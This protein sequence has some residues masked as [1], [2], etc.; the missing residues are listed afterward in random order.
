MHQKDYNL[1]LF[2][3]ILASVAISANAFVISYM[4]YYRYLRNIESNAERSL[5]QRV[6]DVL[7]GGLRPDSST[8]SACRRSFIRNPF[9]FAILMLHVSNIGEEITLIPWIYKGNTGL[10]VF[11]EAVKYYFSL[12]NCFSWF[13][14]IQVYRLL[15]FSDFAKGNVEKVTIGDTFRYF[16]YHPDFRFFIYFMFF[17]FPLV[18]FIPFITGSYR[19]SSIPWCTTSINSDFYVGFFLE[20]FWT[21]LA[22]FACVITNVYLFLKIVLILK[23]SK[24]LNRYLRHAGIYS[25]IALIAWVPRS[26]FYILDASTY[27]ENFIQYVPTYFTGIFF[28]IIIAKLSFIMKIKIFL[29]VI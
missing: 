21:W 23:D 13:F 3:Y 15:L 29:K 24:L 20:Y 8:L 7:R 5:A 19:S 9:Y 14:L 28:C 10:C 12:M 18:C 17:V 27:S 1:F 11:V 22:L 6:C 16:R 25:F 4:I 26:V 2:Y